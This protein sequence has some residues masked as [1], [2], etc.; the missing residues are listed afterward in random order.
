VATKTVPWQPCATSFRQAIR[1]QLSSSSLSRSGSKSSSVW[2]TMNSWCRRTS[3][4][5]TAATPYRRAVSP[6]GRPNPDLDTE[7]AASAEHV[8][9]PVETMPADLV[10]KAE[11]EIWTST[12]VLRRLA[13]HGRS[14]LR[15]LHRLARI[16]GR[17]PLTKPDRL[18]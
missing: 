1:R 2:L 15:T 11:G 3:Q 17:P 16:A 18:A 14:E 5:A 13:W 4:D 10:R 6:P 9:Q 7:L 12:K 8:R